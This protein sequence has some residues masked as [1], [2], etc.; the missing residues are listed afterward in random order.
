MEYTDLTAVLTWLAIGG[1]GAVV[2]LMS[3]AYLAENWGKWHS[4]PTFVKSAVPMILSIAV[5]L[6]A[7]AALD[8]L[9]GIITQIAPWFK[10]AI[11]AL[12]AYLASQREYVKIKGTQYGAK[13]RA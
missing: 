6:G 11:I 8:F 1:G 9:P 4:L 13:Y 12:M 3:F 10:I 2:T 7:Q 5:A